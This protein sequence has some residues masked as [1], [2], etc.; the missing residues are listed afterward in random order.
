MSRPTWDNYFLKIARAV[1]DRSTCN[2]AY[3]GCVLVREGHILATGFNG[4][5]TGQPHCD[6][7]GHLMQEGHCIRTVH[8]EANAIIQAALHGVSTKDAVVYLTHFP[9]YTCAKMLTN[10]GIVRVIFEE[11]YGESRDA[12][13]L[14]NAAGIGVNHV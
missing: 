14:L 8:A 13:G 10:A 11:W 2:R 1:A 6:E 5:P 3:V 7:V 12:F 4:S 9:C